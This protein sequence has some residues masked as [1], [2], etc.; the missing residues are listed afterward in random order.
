MTRTIP[1]L[2]SRSK[3]LS[4]YTTTPLTTTVHAVTTSC[5]LLLVH[6]GHS[7]DLVSNH[8]RRSQLWKECNFLVF[9]ILYV[10][11]M[12]TASSDST[13][14]NRAPFKRRSQLW[15]D[16]KRRG[17]IEKAL[18]SVV[19]INTGDHGLGTECSVE[20]QIDNA[21]I[22]N[23][24][25]N[26]TVHRLS[27]ILGKQ[28]SDLSLFNNT[29]RPRSLG[30]EVMLDFEHSAVRL[31]STEHDLNSVLME[32]RS[33]C[34]DRY[35]SLFQQ[36]G[37]VSNRRPLTTQPL[38]TDGDAEQLCFLTRTAHTTVIRAIGISQHGVFG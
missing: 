3:W 8:K 21:I 17:A 31:T 10:F 33:F 37:S 30:K 11:S 14:R 38:N 2:F 5:R 20:T 27:N 15:K 13:H 24:I 18:P 19:E 29:S 25:N 16:V 12:C 23:A 26:V 6:R 7:Q 34:D 36:S 35:G 28:T 22:T 4:R 32:S 9:M 1:A